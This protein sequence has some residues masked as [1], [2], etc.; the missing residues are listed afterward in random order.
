MMC[1]FIEWQEKEIELGVREAPVNKT[2]AAKEVARRMHESGDDAQGTWS[3]IL[4][5][6]DDE[7][8]KSLKSS[9]E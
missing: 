2:E 3:S 7:V 9:S 5:T 1:G 8:S 4:E 6:Y